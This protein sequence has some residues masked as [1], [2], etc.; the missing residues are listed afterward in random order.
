VGRRFETWTKGGVRQVALEAEVPAYL[1]PSRLAGFFVATRVRRIFP[2]SAFNPM[3]LFRREYVVAATDSDMAILRLKLPAIFRGTIAG[4]EQ[5]CARNAVRINWDGTCL[6][7]NDDE[8]FPIPFHKEDA[9]RV[10]E[11]LTGDGA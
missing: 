11:L 8:Y 5:R 3:A 2:I 7:V 6:R 10:A 9:D 4:L 1:A